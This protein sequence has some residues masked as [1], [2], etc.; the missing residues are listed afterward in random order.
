MYS[1][2]TLMKLARQARPITIKRKRG[3]P[4]MMPKKIS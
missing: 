1:G 4:R 3:S 2:S